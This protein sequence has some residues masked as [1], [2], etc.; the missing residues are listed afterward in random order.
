M[1]KE[2]TPVNDHE[3]LFDVAEQPAFFN[4]WVSQGQGGFEIRSA[5]HG[6][7]IGNPTMQ[8]GP[9]AG[10]GPYQFKERAQG[11]YLRYER[12]AFKHWRTTPDFPEFEFR[13]MREASTRLASLMTGEIQVTNLPEDLMA[14]ATRQG[15]QV[16]KGQ[17]AGPRIFFNLY[18]CF[19]KDLQKM[20]GYLYPDSP[21]MDVRVRKALQKAINL[22]EV[23]KSFFGGKGEI[24]YQPHLHTSRPGWKTDW[25]KDFAEEY[26]YNP[27][28]AKKLLA[29]AGYGPGKPLQTN[30]HLINLPQ[31]PGT[32]DLVEAVGQYWR[33]IG[34]DV[35]LVEMDG[36]E[37][38][39]LNRELKFSNDIQVSG[40][41]SVEFIGH[42]AY[43]T[44]VAPRG[45]FEDPDDDKFYIEKIRNELDDAK[46][47]ALWSELGDRVYKKHY[48]IN[49]LWLPAEAVVNPKFVS[50]YQYPGNITGTWT[51]VENIKAAK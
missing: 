42:Q 13:L 33:A 5:K 38:A 34:V 10:S 15:M 25:V 12:T 28:A 24:M 6:E 37:R 44:S 27:D 43:F 51:H 1:I 29:E 26:G 21:L 3:V 17:V 18:C 4:Y 9:L 7:A 20:E 14:Q 11:Q 45:G 32:T 49:V 50:A 22:E 35:K 39:R 2:I 16:I 19:I 23:N 48:A 8:T 40:T 30:L 46:R 47:A 36:A 41:S 31:F